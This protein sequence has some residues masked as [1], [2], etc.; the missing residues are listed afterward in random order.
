M[1]GR[2]EAAQRTPSV[3]TPFYVAAGPI[4]GLLRACN[5]WARAF[6]LFLRYKW[7]E[8]RINAEEED[9]EAR[10]MRWDRLHAQ[11]APHLLRH[12]LQ[13]R[14]YFIKVGQFA[15]SRNDFIPARVIKELSK[16]QGDV[17]GM[18]AAQVRR[19]MELLSDMVLKS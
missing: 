5:F 8:W 4:R 17:P 10:E 9:D 19:V 1:G 2:W 16:L 13:L 3:A 12:I 6:P 14:G 18:S 15:S 7:A 11:Y